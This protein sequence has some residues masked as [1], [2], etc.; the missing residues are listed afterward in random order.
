M[1]NKIIFYVLIVAYGFFS[2]CKEADVKKGITT[3]NKHVLSDDDI[4]LAHVNGT[5]ITKYD[6]EKT[7]NSTLKVSFENKK[8][9]NV[10]KKILE[11]LIAS[12]AI[13]IEQEKKLTEKDKAELEKEVQALKEQLLVKKYLSE[14]IKAEPINEDM[15]RKYYES[16]LEEFGANKIRIYEMIASEQSVIASE[17][18]GLIKGLKESKSKKDLQELSNDL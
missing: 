2:G 10:R 15:A 13:A 16:H 6:V 17:R 12:R 11:S 8:D 18:D 3:S 1:N 9:E 5:P 14:H 7:I 4:V